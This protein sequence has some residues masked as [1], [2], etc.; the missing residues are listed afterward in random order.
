MR[1]LGG[2]QFRNFA[3]VSFCLLLVKSTIK[4]YFSQKYLYQ[5]RLETVY[6]TLKD[7]HKERGF[8]NKQ[9]FTLIKKVFGCK[10]TDESEKFWMVYEY[11]EIF[12][13]L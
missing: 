1:A 4:L 5:D 9:T 13:Q 10:G 11:N 12:R 7:I 8:E 3:L 6:L 2:T